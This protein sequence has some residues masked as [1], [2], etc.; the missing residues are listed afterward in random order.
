MAEVAIGMRGIRDFLV[1]T[2]GSGEARSLAPLEDLQHAKSDVLDALR[3][4]AREVGADAVVG[5]SMRY[6]QLGSGINMLLVVAMGTAVRLASRGP[7][8]PEGSTSA[9]AP[10]E[11][12]IPVYRFDPAPVR[13][14]SRET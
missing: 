9:G 3:Q 5:V 11:I 13:E 6:E 7:Q 8:T 12:G 14:D 10:Q 2:L 4:K 1:G